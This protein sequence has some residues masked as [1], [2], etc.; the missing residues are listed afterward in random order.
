MVAEPLLDELEKGEWPS[1]VTQMKEMAKT[2]PMAKD[3]CA[4]LE[5]SYE[6]KI[7][8]WKHGGL[9]GVQGYGAGVI[10]RYTNIKGLPALAGG[11][12]SIRV[13]EQSRVVFRWSD[14]AAHGV[15]LLDYHKG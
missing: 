12:H 14:G 5:K 7:T 15:R 4:Q 13:N 1:F 10:G 11:F 2:N 9:V 6:D 3:L 8:H